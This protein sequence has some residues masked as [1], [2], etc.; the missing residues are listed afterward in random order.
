MVNIAHLL[1]RWSAAP[2]RILY[3]QNLDGRWRDVSAREVLAYAARWQ[4]FLRAQGFAAGERVALCLK[5][6]IHWVAADQAALGLGLV[7]V[8]LYVDD[9][10]ENVAFCLE[11]SGAR[12]LVVET[13]SMA[14][15][16]SKLTP[17]LPRILCVSTE[18]G[19]GREQ[20]ESALPEEAT[21][22]E[23]V[24]LD[25]GALA[26]I[27][28]TS[29]TAGRPKGVMLTHGNVLANV[30]ACERTR[31]ARADDVFLSFLPLSHMFE[32]TGGYYL[33]LSL[34]AKVA[35]ARSV[36][37]LAEDL[38]SERPTVIFAVPRVFE[39]FASRVNEALAKAP[40]RKRLFDLVVAAGGR[41][42]RGEAGVVDRFVLALLQRRI[43]A[44]V[45]AR[46]G[47]RMRL[48]VLGGAPLDPGIAWLFLGLG[49][50]VLQGYGMTEASPVIAV[51]RVEDNVPESVGVPLD[52]VEVKIG[53]GGELLARGPSI[54]K[55]Y[56]NLPDA[57]EK[58]LDREGWLHTGDLAELRGG[59]IFISG[60]L[61]DVLV[62]SNGEKLPPQDVELAILG[63]PVFE[64]GILIGE[65]RPFLTLLTVT[66]ESDERSLVHRANERLRA[67]PR[68]I[69]V[70]RVVTT[71]DPWTVENGLLTPTLKVKRE[72]VQKKFSSEIELAYSGG[73]LD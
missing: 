61:K 8:P 72:G 30:S 32:R 40:A 27:C 68:Y 56:W 66:R 46:L 22:F 18:P 31:L 67:F 69:R 49:L 52:N 1:K 28:Y 16:L 55:G 71:R 15:A 64:Q 34:G 20:V 65:G 48:A 39:R 58:A 54:M 2:E 21:E 41:A 63:D 62:L 50:P 53:S 60:R 44:P 25:E 43:S 37:Q 47:G 11:N 4:A 35:H 70:R 12:L 57:T 19:G 59:K 3:R 17:A 51:N 26:T 14:D 23:V 38:A 29:G 6:G 45:L 9:N 73:T 10:P 24:P 5:N 33:P 42:A 13:G 7:V 36:S